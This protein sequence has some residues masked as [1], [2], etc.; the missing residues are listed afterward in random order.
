MSELFIGL[1]SGTSLDGADAVLADFSAAQPKVLAHCHAPFPADL[2]AELLALQQTVPDELHRSALAACALA[3]HYAALVA[4]LLK[5]TDLQARDINAIAAHGQTVRHR[6]ELGYTL[7]LNAPARLAEATRINVIA[8]LRSRDVAAGGHGAPLVPGFHASMLRHA[9]RHRVIVNI[10]GI[11]NLADLPAAPEAPVRG[12]DCGP[13]NVLMDTWIHQQRGLA[14]DANGNWAR[15][16][17]VIPTLLQAL[18]TEPW[19][20]LPPPK[21]TGRDLF[22]N[23]W[24]QSHLQAFATAA[25][26]AIAAPENIQATLAEFTAWGIADGIAHHARGAA[27]V[28]ISGG[29]ALN[30]DLLSRLERQLSARLG[31]ALP[32]QTSAALGI[33]VDQVEALAFAW[34]ARQYQRGLPGNLPSV[35]GAGGLRTLGALYPGS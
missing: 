2:R 20:S 32:V 31:R 15:S 30:A 16:G 6:P 28:I 8:D 9:E 33:P 3:D 19:L 22:N 24:L 29:G 5:Q 25:I 23:D 10:G 21:S 35:T 18:Q 14:F 7:Q 13:G 1:M 17:R 4:G 12:W 26:A 11:A 27:E 34:L